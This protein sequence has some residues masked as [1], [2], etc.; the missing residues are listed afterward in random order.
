[1]KFLE[2]AYDIWKI[3]SKEQ[4]LKWHNND[5]FI[6][7]TDKGKYL[8]QKI[9]DI[10]IEVRTKDYLTIK[11]YLEKQG[12]W[13]L[14]S[15]LIFTNDWEPFLKNDIGYHRISTYIEN[16]H[17]E[18]VNK[19]Q[20]F[21]WWRLLWELHTWIKWVF[22]GYSETF[23]WDIWIR[24]ENIKK[25]KS[26]IQNKVQEDI[27]NKLLDLVNLV[28]VDHTKYVST[29]HGDTKLFNFLYKWNNAIC[30]VDVYD[31][32]NKS[33]LRDIWDALRTFSR[34]KDSTWYNF[35][36]DLAKSFIDWYNKTSFIKLDYEEAIKAY[37]V[38]TYILIS[39]YLMRLINK[40]DSFMTW[41]DLDLDIYY[42]N[43]INMYF[44]IISQAMDYLGIKHWNIF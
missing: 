35:V 12:K 37:I 18:F 26:K 11:A 2:K 7:V 34:E 30:M 14:I 28:V 42:T 10:N 21:S 43:R 15:D 29:I 20:A 36:P 33:I 19:E 38:V 4:L 41:V 17:V 39:R 24:I 9:N 3:I 32:M 22:S 31:F 13:H 23:Y 25:M 44:K 40:D 27:Y 6:L 8:Y 16:D 5:T 1:M